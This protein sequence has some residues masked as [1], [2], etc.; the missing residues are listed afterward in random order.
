VG[1]VD[2][3]VLSPARDPRS[4]LIGVEALGTMVAA[5][6]VAVRGAPAASIPFVVGG[7]CPLLLGCVAGARDR[8]GAVGVLF[9]DGHE[10][11]WP[12]ERSPTGE[13]ADSELGILLG[14][15]RTMLP[16]PLAELPVSSPLDVSVLGARDRS[17]LAEA[18]LPSISGRVT[19]ADDRQLLREGPAAVASRES[20]R[21][22]ARAGRWWLHLDL[23]VLSTAALG[24]VDYRQPGGL[25]WAD[26]AE[27]LPAALAVPG[28]AGVDLTIYNPDLDGGASAPTIVALVG[29][30]FG[31]T[32]QGSN[33]SSADSQ[34]C[35]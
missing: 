10:D 5:T 29:T 25:S 6:R 1:D 18:G 22:H 13:A 24:A 8:Y 17:E 28:L 30:T 26:L 27:L 19:F 14:D 23:D 12:A 9:V 2:V 31:P 35:S 32:G 16:G 11:S 33:A 4:G 34:T 21:L 15:H 20:Q 3:G 7:D